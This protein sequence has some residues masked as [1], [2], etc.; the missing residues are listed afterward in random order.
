MQLDRFSNSIGNNRANLTIST[1]KGIT[2]N[3]GEPLSSFVA[4]YLLYCTFNE[5][6]K[7]QNTWLQKNIEKLIPLSKEYLGALDTKFIYDLKPIKKNNDLL[8]IYYNICNN[9]DLQTQLQNLLNLHQITFKSIDLTSNLVPHI[10][11]TN[12]TTCT[13]CNTKLRRNIQYKKDSKGSIGIIYTNKHGPKLTVHYIQHCN[14]K[15]CKTKYYHGRYE[16][17]EGIYIES[18]EN[19]Y[20]M[21][22]KCT[23]LDDSIVRECTSF[24]YDDGIGIPS[25]CGKYQARFSEE[26]DDIELTL[27]L[28]DQ[29][30]GNRQSFSADLC[31]QRV[32]DGVCTRRLQKR[33]EEDLGEQIFISWEEIQQYKTK[34][35]KIILHA[36]DSSEKVIK[37]QWIECTDLFNLMYD[38]YFERLQKTPDKWLKYVP[39]KEG[40]I[41]L[42]HFLLM[43]DGGQKLTHPIC[44]YPMSL[45]QH[46]LPTPTTAIEQECVRFLRCCEPP[47]KGNGPSKTIVTC[48]HHTKHLRSLG[49]R[50]TLINKY[51]KYI[52][53]KDRLL[54]IAETD[55]NEKVIQKFKKQIAK[56]SEDIQ[57]FNKITAQILQPTRKSARNLNKTYA[58][59]NA[60]QQYEQD[61]QTLSDIETLYKMNNVNPLLLSNPQIAHFIDKER[62]NVNVWND[63]NGCRKGYHVID[64]EESDPLFTRS[65]GLQN[66]MAHDGFIL[67]LGENVHRETPT[68]VLIGLGTL[69]TSDS[70]HIEYSKRIMGV[71]YDMMCC[72]YGRLRTLIDLALLAP[73]IISLFISLLPYLFID[74]FHIV[75][76]K[77]PLCLITGL[78]HP[79]GDK[80][81]GQ[82]IETGGND[83]IVEQNWKVTNKMKYAKNQG[84]RKFRFMLYDFKKRHNDKNWVQLEKKGYTFIPIDQTTTIRDFT[85]INTVLPT[86]DDLLHKKQYQSLKIVK[87]KSKKRK[88]IELNV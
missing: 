46:E 64:H 73:I 79:K 5:S 13:E 42:K 86:T 25:F 84:K 19:T 59:M 23:F 18:I 14:N 30:L 72:L 29:K 12:R 63:I 50:L 53:L 34:Q 10:T 58:N 80:F 51:C 44:G 11:E 4:A 85:K 77:N 60:S 22:T 21:N 24:N 67:Y 87:L 70:D 16:T 57:T 56:F 54:S 37:K 8:N 68:E 9:T 43:G 36:S 82:R 83:S 39:V 15:D 32:L 20:Q 35:E 2:L 6:N 75:T 62:N 52:N 38:K 55:K 71:G 74:L 3:E 76:H 33:I 69:L 65:G 27:T 61:A 49:L 28:L 47:Q 88:K 7:Q 81:K 31:R 41:L 17:E 45:Y 66:W 1:Q 48:I 40:K 26:F 78:F